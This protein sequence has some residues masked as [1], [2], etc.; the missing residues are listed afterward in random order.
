MQRTSVLGD[1]KLDCAAPV[2]PSYPASQE[3]VMPLGTGVRWPL[4]TSSGSQRCCS[5]ITPCYK[6]SISG[7]A[8]ISESRSFTTFFARGGS[9]LCADRPEPGRC[10]NSGSS[11]GP[12]FS[13]DEP[14]VL[15]RRNYRRHRLGHP[16]HASRSG[17]GVLW[18]SDEHPAPAACG[19]AVDMSGFILRT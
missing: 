4:P 3:A 15:R 1:R 19:G 6:A 12:G 11:A 13:A 16:A 5:R 8:Q 17:G 2:S 10:R 18:Q 14:A 9:T 7:R